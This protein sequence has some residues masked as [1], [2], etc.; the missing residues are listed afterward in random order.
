VSVNLFDRVLKLEKESLATR[1]SVEA[2][3]RSI[4][5]VVFPEQDREAK[6]KDVKAAVRTE[7]GKITGV[8]PET[9]TTTGPVTLIRYKRGGETTAWEVKNEDP[10]PKE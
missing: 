8:D 3:A 7:F 9:N 6:L 2:I 10:A 5:A 4:V 1:A